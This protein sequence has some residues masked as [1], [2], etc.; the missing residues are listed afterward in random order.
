MSCVR[1]G[2]FW[3]SFLFA[4]LVTLFGLAVFISI[5]GSE[6]MSEAEGW[7]VNIAHQALSLAAGYAYGRRQFE[8]QR[9][10]SRGFDVVTGK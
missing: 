8:K 2:T 3:A 6:D 10:K 4:W 1:S 7:A 5:F 9:R